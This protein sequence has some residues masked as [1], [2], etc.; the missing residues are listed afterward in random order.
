[1]NLVP[2]R[3]HLRGLVVVA[4]VVTI[5]S[6][7]ASALLTTPA[8]GG[9]T[10][11]PNGTLVVTIDGTGP[12]QIVAYGPD[13][14]LRYRNDTWDLY[15]DV[16]PSPAGEQTVMYVASEQLPDDRCEQG[17]CLLNVI[18]RVNLTT[19]EVTR[20]HTQIDGKA[21][22]SQIHDVDRVNESVLLVGD[23]NHPDRV[24]TLNTTTDE[25]LWEWC[26]S[27]AYEPESGGA[28]PTDWTHLNDVEY[29]ADGRVMVSLRNHDQVV[30]L[31]PGEG[32]QENWTL[33]ADDAYERLFEQH[34]PDYIP[35][36]RGGPAVVVA[37]SENNRVVEYQRVNG[38]WVRSWAWADTR[39]QW[40][41]DADRLPDGRTL[42]TDTHG[43]RLLVVDETGA[44]TWSTPFP[45]G[46]YDAEL[47][48]TGN[49]GDES[50]G[51]S[52]RRAGLA[53]KEPTPGG[54]AIGYRLTRFVPPRVL[55][56]VLFA[57]PR[58]TDPLDAVLVIAT[59]GVVAV[60]LLV[61]IAAWVRGSV[62]AS[63]I[64]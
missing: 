25:V 12:G 33:G 11:S 63:A 3:R 49:T 54:V 40:P 55:H 52:A 22:S 37:D 10:G 26:V 45:D 38:S 5:A 28:Y 2:G 27:T 35:R 30:F 58:W 19:G 56:G 47:L 53:S 44:I 36:E 7:A 29:T 15:H 42:V 59:G 17:S 62:S 23:I 43:E 4:V 60:W 18:E 34:N 41:R 31:E 32:L 39:M 64:R 57:L 61:E 14:Q 21:G 24:Y 9:V 46:A 13:G 16:D 20:L 6:L 8:V 48:G 50:V 51:P 1:M